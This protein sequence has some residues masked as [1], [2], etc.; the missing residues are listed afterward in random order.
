MASLRSSA[1]CFNNLGTFTKVS[2][3]VL[4]R[5][6][7]W[8]AVSGS[9]VQRLHRLGSEVPVS[10]P[11]LTLNYVKMLARLL[12]DP[13]LLLSVLRLSQEEHQTVVPSKFQVAAPGPAYRL[14]PL[15]LVD[16]RDD[17][18]EEVHGVVH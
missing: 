1:A 6:E 12:K 11:H 18:N 8:G 13:S 14:T 4:S 7:A 3:S 10:L 17:H 9:Q 2:S 16:R 15:N 5:N